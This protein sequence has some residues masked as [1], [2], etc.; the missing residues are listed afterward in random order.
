MLVDTNR[1]LL[2][3]LAHVEIYLANFGSIKK[4]S[5]KIHEKRIDENTKYCIDFIH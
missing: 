4:A 2:N 3:S 5:S 1:R